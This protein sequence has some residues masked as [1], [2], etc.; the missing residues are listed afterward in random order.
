MATMSI[1]ISD[2]DKNEADNLFKE[3]KIN[4]IKIDSI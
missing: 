2:A 1:R 3:S 4:L